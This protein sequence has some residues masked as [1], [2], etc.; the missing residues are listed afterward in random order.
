MLGPAGTLTRS[1]AVVSEFA[2]AALLEL[3]LSAETTVANT[4][5]EAAGERRGWRRLRPVE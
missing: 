3:L 1:V 4:L 5:R 2:L